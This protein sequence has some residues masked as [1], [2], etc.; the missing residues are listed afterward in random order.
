MAKTGED[1][2]YFFNSSCQKGDSC[3]F[4][5]SPGAIGQPL[6]V[7]WSESKFCDVVL[8]NFRHSNDVK[9]R[10]RTQC[11]WETQPSGCQKPHCPFFHKARQ[12]VSIAQRVLS[13]PGQNGETS[14]QVGFVSKRG[15]SAVAPSKDVAPKQNATNTTAPPPVS[16]I[17]KHVEPVPPKRHNEA[18]IKIDVSRFTTPA[19]TQEKKVKPTNRQGP[20]AKIPQTNKDANGTQV[21]INFYF[22][23]L[24]PIPAAHLTFRV[25]ACILLV[26]QYNTEG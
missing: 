9:D 18:K 14:A 7:N 23:Y 8:C 11:Y 6:C 3:P 16:I 25:T 4:R 22:R 5:H 20:K 15:A 13:T 26:F 10:S 24:S 2:Y 19:N 12:A 17:K 1:C 21:R